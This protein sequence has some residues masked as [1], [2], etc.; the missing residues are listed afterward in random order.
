MNSICLYLTTVFLAA[1]SV[2]AQDSTFSNEFNDG[3]YVYWQSVDTARVFYVCNGSLIDSLYEVQDTLS[4]R[5]FG[6]DS[7]NVYLLPRVRQL[8]EKTTYQTDSPIAAISDIHGDY[9]H[10]IEWLKVA[11]VV[12]SSLTWSFDKG[13]LVVLGDVTDRGSLVTECLWLIHRL[14][15]EAEQAGGMVHMIL[16]NHEKMV[17][18]G[19]LRYVH[20][21]YIKGTARKTRIPYD[22][23]YGSSMELGRWLRSSPTA[24]IINDLLFVHGG[25]SP[26]LL[27]KSLSLEQINTET[28]A[29]LDY[30]NY[31]TAFEPEA[32]F[33]ISSAG[34]LWSRDYFPDN[35]DSAGVTALVQSALDRYGA[36]TIV[37]GHTGHEQ[38]Q[39]LYDQRLIGIDV[40]VEELGYQQGLLWKDGRTLLVSGNG[41]ISAVDL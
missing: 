39:F 33:M 17:M 11:G 7:S 9:D 1:T 40:W 12:D 13:H 28:S 20:P 22:D 18:R 21:K 14:Q 4:F 10:L 19:D 24:I 35:P 29:A 27:E 31:K 32:R 36:K 34:P 25:I 3:P 15:Q 41:A 6:A 26:D 37:V 8:E 16:G 30:S 38:V 2:V 23:L 5:G